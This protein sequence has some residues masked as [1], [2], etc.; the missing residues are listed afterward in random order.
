[1]KLFIPAVVLIML[2]FQAS[3]CQPRFDDSILWSVKN[4]KTDKTTYILG[5]C[6]ILDTT[7]INFPISRI[8]KLIDR[9]QYVWVEISENQMSSMAYQAQKLMAA[10]PG[11]PTL[12]DCLQPKVREM[13]D[14]RIKSSPSLS[15]RINTSIPLLS[16]YGLMYLIHFDETLRNLKFP[17][18]K[19]FYM[20]SFFVAYAKKK[21]KGVLDL[22]LARDKLGY[23]FPPDKTF[24]EKVELLEKVIMLDQKSPEFVYGFYKNQM[25]NEMGSW[26]DSDSTHIKRNLKMARRLDFS[27][28]DYELFVMFGAAHLGG[29]NGVL[30]LLAK[31]GYIIKPE[32]ITIA[33]KN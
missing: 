25:I 20:D 7:N 10:T 23:L 3:S 15:S 27:M 28:Q 19:V 29:E 17:K 18:D 13:L 5:T 30:N 6:H 16:P 11:D 26:S 21:N 1:M 12:P 4:P 31:K 9:A 2:G 24:E 14:Q 32:K 22:E 33:D 8:Y